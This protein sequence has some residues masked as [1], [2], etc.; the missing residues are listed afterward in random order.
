MDLLPPGFHPGRLCSLFPGKQL[1]KGWDPKSFGTGT[2]PER[3]GMGWEQ[4]GKKFPAGIPKRALFGTGFAVWTQIRD[5]S[6]SFSLGD[7]RHAFPGCSPASQRSRGLHSLLPLHSIGSGSGSGSPSSSCS[8]SNS[9]CDPWDPALREIWDEAPSPRFPVGCG[10]LI[11]GIRG[12]RVSEFSGQGSGCPAPL[13]VWIHPC[14]P[15]KSWSRRILDPS[16]RCCWQI[17]FP[18]YSRDHPSDLGSDS[19]SSWRIPV[20]PQLIFWERSTPG[21]PGIFQNSA[22]ASSTLFQP[23]GSPG[24]K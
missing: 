24:R 4:P 23:L 21:I 2:S 8:G 17:P 14:S 11:W 3:A 7:F 1:G 20:S 19:L 22:A 9:R 10:Y 12:L 13:P 5:H 16:Q 15:G 18:V 6:H